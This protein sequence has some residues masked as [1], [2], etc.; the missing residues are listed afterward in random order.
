MW[1]RYQLLDKKKEGEKKKEYREHKRIKERV[2]I[3]QYLTKYMYEKNKDGF[4]REISKV[5][6]EEIYEKEKQISPNNVSSL[7]EFIRTCSR[8]YYLKANYS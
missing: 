2:K 7:A 6:A 1:K 8:K 4:L 3:I 5:R